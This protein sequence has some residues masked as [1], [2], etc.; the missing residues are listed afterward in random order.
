MLPLSVRPTPKLPPERDDLISGVLRPLL[1]DSLGI[2]V[3]SE[4]VVKRGSA[5]DQ[6]TMERSSDPG[7]QRETGEQFPSLVPQYRLSLS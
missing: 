2:Q 3:D 7:G 1:V 6:R 5:G 4:N